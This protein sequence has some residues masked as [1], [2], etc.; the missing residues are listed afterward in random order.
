VG[1]V[2]S[3]Q[4]LILRCREHKQHGERIV[5]AAG[6]FDFLHPGH[7]RLLEQ[8]R[9]YGEILVVAVLGDPSVQ[10][11]FRASAGKI[12][13]GRGANVKRPVTPAT[14]R[15]E[16]LAA[17]AAVDYVT[18]SE[19][20]GLPHLLAELR[21]DAAVESAE[22]SSPALLARDAPAAGVRLV[23]IPFEPGHSTAAIIER[24]VQLSGSE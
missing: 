18:P 20:A 19:L 12:P 3:Q 13:A 1:K 10:E 17:L 7:V 4:D 24:I 5:F 11:L 22:P 16:I 23:R 8:A 15:A 21:P 6:C 2:V 14:E 9:D